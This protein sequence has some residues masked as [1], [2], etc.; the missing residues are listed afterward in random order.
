MKFTV[1]TDK[2]DLAE[3]LEE[4][5]RSEAKQAVR[6]GVDIMVAEIQANA[7]RFTS[8][9]SRP[10]H[11]PVRRTGE[12]AQSFKRGSVR[13]GRDKASVTGETVSTLSYEEV[14]GVEY[15]HT[16]PTGERVLPRAFIRPAQVTAEPKIAAL[17][18]RRF[19]R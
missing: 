12:L 8:G 15:G 3:E 13:L 19:A 16:K 6:D 4:E 2:I 9:E 7:N 17:F 11:F 5:F 14:N 10:G 18:A 1:R